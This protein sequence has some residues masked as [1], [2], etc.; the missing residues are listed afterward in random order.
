MVA[1]DGAFTKVC[2]LGFKVDY[3]LGDFDSSNPDETVDQEWQDS[4]EIVPAPDQN[5]TDLEKGI[6]FLMQK[7]ATEIN[8]IWADGK[9]LDHMLSN[10]SSLVRYSKSVK[11]VLWNDWSK[12]YVL[13]HRFEK[14][15]EKGAILSLLPAPLAKGISTQG[16]KYALQNEDL[17]FG[18]RTGSSNESSVDGMVSIQ[19]E[20]GD[21]ILIEAWD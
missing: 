17:E 2:Q 9:R 11:L 12:V 8:I 5:K 1:L 4:V 6:E 14:W 20:E 19:H 10:I 16:L 7:G 13:P 15:F 3:W 21:L 18:V